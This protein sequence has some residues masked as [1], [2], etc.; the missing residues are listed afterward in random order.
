MNKMDKK[1]QTGMN[2]TKG[3]VVGILIILILGVV[4]IVIAVQL[5]DSGILT[6]N[7]SEANQTT[8]IVANYSKGIADFFVQVPTIMIIAALVILIAA[9]VILVVLISSAAR[10]AGGG[11]G[12]L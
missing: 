7:S 10:T 6:A 4:G 5:R 8:Q 3:L 11:R 2:L 9:L 12:S 1:G